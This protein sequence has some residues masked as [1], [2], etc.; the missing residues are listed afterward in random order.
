MSDLNDLVVFAAC[1]DDVVGALIAL[2]HDENVM[3]DTT[4]PRRTPH[5]LQVAD[6]TLYL[7]VSFRF[8]ISYY[9]CFS[10]NITRFPFLSS[11]Q[12]YFRTH[13]VI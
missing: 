3:N 5:T 1:E 2:V 4:V 13:Y 6:H 10:V 8:C 12:R 9:I 7:L 11:V